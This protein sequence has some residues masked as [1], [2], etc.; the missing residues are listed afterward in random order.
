MVTEAY[1][2][3]DLGLKRKNN[4][5][6]YYLNSVFKTD[7]EVSKED[8]YE[9][10]K[11]KKNL[12]AVCD[13]MGGEEYG[14]KASLIAVDT[15]KDFQ[16]TDFNKNIHNYI[17]VANNSI[18]DFITANSGKRSGT[19]FA[20]VF[21]DGNK[22]RSYNVGDSRVYLF[23]DRQLMRLS[24]DHTR[25]QQLINMGILTPQDA[26]T[27]K[28]RHVI[29]QY[30][31]I[32]PEELEVSPYISDEIKIKEGDVF[33]L[34]SDGL[35]DMVDDSDIERILKG[36]KDV[37]EAA[38]R[39]VDTALE[40]GGKDNVTVELIKCIKTKNIFRSVMLPLIVAGIA[41]TVA[42]IVTLM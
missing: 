14:E 12:Y 31:G 28:D 30:L 11:S 8:F 2:I 25:V 32:F 16:N 36:K 5:D 21:I 34:C 40:N 10:S 24:V 26:K 9:I 38:K 39:L 33:L 13:G 41:L 19:T 7:T 37:K 42:A 29:T 23:R 3:T 35:Y 15:L 18:C 17:S 22:A 1:V 6:N 4:E 27:H 20:S